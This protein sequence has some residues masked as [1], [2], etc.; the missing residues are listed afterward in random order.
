MTEPEPEICADCGEPTCAG[1]PGEAERR[2]EERLAASMS[3][4]RYGLRQ[5]RRVRADAPYRKCWRCQLSVTRDLVS[6][7]LHRELSLRGFTVRVVAGIGGYR[8]RHPVSH[9][10]WFGECLDLQMHAFAEFVDHEIAH[11]DMSCQ[12][13]DEH[14]AWLI[15][16][17][18]SWP[19]LRQWLHDDGYAIGLPRVFPEGLTRADMC[20]RGWDVVTE[21]LFDPQHDIAPRT[22]VLF[23]HI[24]AP[25]VAGLPAKTGE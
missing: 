24:P 17:S 18:G 16:T 5:R 13:D 15:V 14:P 20:A 11:T 12:G 8:S 25:P 23:D 21:P 10:R 2:A 22:K 1:A 9:C 19:S 3:A 4:V 7:L 6:A